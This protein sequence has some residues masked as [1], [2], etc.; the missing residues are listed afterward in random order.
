MKAAATVLALLGL[1]LLALAQIPDLSHCQAWLAYDGPETPTVLVYPDGQGRPFTEARLPDGTLVDATVFLLVL[2]WNDNPIA[3]FPREDIW[4]ESYDGGLFHCN[5]GTI[6]DVNTDA[7]GLTWWSQPMEAGG[8]SED[9][10]MVLVN[11]DNV[12]AEGLALNFNSP[13]IDGDGHVGL[14]DVTWL[15]MDFFGSYH[16]R[17]DLQRDGVINL[18]DLGRLAAGLGGQC[19]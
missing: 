16:F 8:Y 2:D 15:A 4:L 3:A 14:P 9:L 18:S 13:D 5:G 11:G 12:W 17:S 10:T 7:E 1:P 6:A 19:P